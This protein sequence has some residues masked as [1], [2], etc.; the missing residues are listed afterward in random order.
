MKHAAPI[1]A[2]LFGLMWLSPLLA[3]FNPQAIAPMMDY[4]EAHALAPVAN[5]MLAVGGFDGGATTAACEWYD[6]AS[7][8]WNSVA[9]LPEPRQDATAHGVADAVFVVGGWNGGS[10]NFDDILRYDAAS[11]TWS[12]VATLSHGRSGHRS[13]ATSDGILICG[14]YDGSADLASCDLFNT[15]TYAVTPVADMGTARSSFA[16]VHFSHNG[17]A[18][19]LVAGGFNPNEGFQLD[20][21]EIFDGSAWTAAADLPWAVDNLAG[22][23]TYG[24]ATPVVSGGRIFNGADNLFEGIAQGALYDAATD[25]WAAFD[26]QGPH[27]YHGM[28]SSTSPSSHIWVSGGADETG[29]GVT[30]TFTYAEAGML[31]SMAPVIPFESVT[32]PMECAGR[33]RAAVASEGEWLYVTGGDESFVGTGYRVNLGLPSGINYA[34]APAAVRVFPNPSVGRSVLIGAGAATTWQLMDQQGRCV[35]TGSGPELDLSACSVGTYTLVTNDGR[36]VT[37]IRQR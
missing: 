17:A 13:V 18:L 6:P 34:P 22:T 7:D 28:A 23:V 12:V 25:T 29:N 30:T 14:G 16:M 10:T 36:N 15:T 26:T 1:L 31:E 3:Q 35:M 24:G 19:T 11:D 9:S 20:G 27:S 32:D 4:R 37:V 21:C 8:V 33:F 5:G 2:T